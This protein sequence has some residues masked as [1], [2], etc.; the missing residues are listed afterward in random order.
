MAKSPEEYAHL[1]WLG[2]VQPIGLIVSVPAMLEAQCYINKN[3]GGEHTC[4]LDCLPRDRNDEIIPEINDFPA[5]AQKCLEWEPDDL[6]EIP[7]RVP[8]PEELSS[9]EVILP[10]YHETL[11]P[12]HAVPV[13][14]PKEGQIPWNML[15]QVLP[16]G[17]GFD[18]PSEADSSRHWHASP[19]L[20]FERLLRETSVSIGLLCNSRQL[21]LVYA[22]RGESSGHATFNVDEMV[23]VAG[24]PMFAAMHMLLSADRMF[25]L[26]EKQRL[27]AILEN[28]RKYQ[29]TVS[30]KLSEQV[31]AALYEL[32]RGLQ[33]ATD[34]RKGELLR[35]VL[36]NN[37][38]KVYSGLLR[39]LMRLVFVLYAEDRDLMSSDPV[40]SNNYS[41]TGLFERLRSDAGRF[42]DTM[43][44]RF[45]AWSQLLTLFRLVYEGGQHDSFKLPARKG[46]LF[47]PD[48]Y[49]FLEGRT[50]SCPPDEP[51]PIPRI[52]DGVV[53]RVLRNLLIL[54]GERLS[55]R[56]LDVEQIGSVYETM[57]GFNLEVAQGQ[58]I[59]I[60]PVKS[61]GAPAT[62]NLDELLETKDKDRAKWINE[63]TDQKITGQALKDLKAAD[64]IDD[65]L[66]ALNKKIAKKVTPQVVPQGSIVLQ[67][68]DERRR[69]G[70]H[71][72]PRSLTKPI[73]ETTLQPILKQLV[74]PPQ[75]ETKGQKTLL[76]GKGRKTKIQAIKSERDE[77][78]AKLAQEKGTPHPRQIL[79]LKICD[80]AMGSG[81]F[82]VETCRQLADELVAAWHAHECVPTAEIPPDEDEILYARR[83]V[84]Q[85][86]LYGVDKNPMA[87]D[88]TKLSLWL[89]TLAK[90][91][92]FTF[93]DHSL[94]HGDSLVGLTAD[95]IAGFT[96]EQK[97][98]KK[99]RGEGVTFMSNIQSRLEK[100]TDYRKKILDAREDSPYRDQ[101][102]RM[103]LAEEALSLP[104]MI[105]DA[106]ISAFFSEN[107]KNARGERRDRL[108]AFLTEW[109]QS[110]LSPD[111]R[112]PIGDA[113]ESLRTG[114]H[115]LP[116]FHWEI[117]FPEVFGRENG[118]FDSFVGNPP[119]FW[120]NRI[121]RVF[122]PAYRDWLLGTN[123]DALGNA[124]LVTL[125]LRCGFTHSH[126]YGTTGLI[127]TNTVAETDTRES[128]L[129]YIV[130]QRGHIFAARRDFRWPG[131]ASVRVSVVHF[132]R[133]KYCKACF[134]DGEQVPGIGTDL[135]PVTGM[136]AIALGPPKTLE[137]NANTAF[138]GID[139]GGNGFQLED[140]E[141]EDIFANFPDELPF[142]WPVLN[143]QDFSA[144]TNGQ[145]IRHIINFSGIEL[146]E[147]TKAARCIGIVR[148]RVKPMRDRKKGKE[149]DVWWQFRRTGEAYLTATE[150]MKHVLICPVVAK[151]LTFAFYPRRVVFTNALN[152]F[153]FD[154]YDAFC[155]LQSQVHFIWAIRHASTLRTDTRYN[156]TDCFETFPMPQ[157]WNGNTTLLESGTNL[158]LYRSELMKARK[159]GFTTTYNRFHNPDE[160]SPETRKLRELHEELDRAVLKAYEW[161]QLAEQATCDFVIDTEEQ[162]D[163]EAP[164]QKSPKKES[165]RYRW[166]DQ[167]RDEVLARLLELNEQ[168]AME[169]KLAGKTATAAEEKKAEKSKRRAIKPQS[170]STSVLSGL[171]DDIEITDTDRV[172]LIL[173]TAW[174]EHTW[175]DRVLFG[176]A[177]LLWK[178]NRHRQYLL[179]RGEEPQRRPVSVGS[180]SQV[181]GRAINQ[182]WFTPREGQGIQWVRLSQVPS[183]VGE[184]SA[185]ELTKLQEVRSVVER[186][187]ES[188]EVT[189]EQTED[190]IRATKEFV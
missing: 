181:I 25:T 37:P 98:S 11:R 4:F 87:V 71:Y 120:G 167:F 138:K 89:A 32:M 166:P 47:D 164:M 46:Y 91:H 104:R 125:F 62:I 131:E 119:F 135:R 93:L 26:G 36:A 55:Y 13:F 8:L 134:L 90:D 115:P 178:N 81:A 177:L 143:A 28:S 84:A 12:T 113:A 172:A 9:L 42:P 165:C 72:T 60:K 112:Q 59:A 23:Q 95:Q 44:S 133:R 64:S 145:P 63:Q 123:K 150:Q 122:G 140:D 43:D 74:E 153:A 114:E 39:V 34:I 136:S 20:K 57:M 132:S 141:V 86:C 159:E 96:W 80:P 187:R 102:Q 58:S 19:Q 146:H 54:D 82:L 155:V 22:P 10:Q 66:T 163:D 139:F 53:Y 51:A 175:V 130:K 79:N 29:S 49:P 38:N 124:D 108:F 127:T 73:V 2:Y 3:I 7:Q 83:L 186:I 182:G 157:S 121:S 45:G 149:R 128:G 144:T 75:E 142:V 97:S 188:D 14:K 1:E 109:F 68:S 160:K 179:G 183:P 106:C 162:H 189:I 154:G 17:T 85:R 116:P 18:E 161:D 168:R 110:N 174:G 21:R 151:H 88:L 33:S 170:A 56:T 6:K 190:S 103:A 94:R 111:K 101:E 117:E 16:T 65:L 171:F 67:P 61:H 173:V 27:P 184:L 40:Y 156:P 76:D 24:R 30:T 41:I 169:E 92:P 69:S 148:D 70:S 31:L 5:F 152:I 50:P 100:A 99:K 185:D 176:Q 180:L 15:I 147:A 105:G 35:E 107:K 137:Q 126:Q 52:S 48:A 158:Y 78:A 77:E 118:G 129:G